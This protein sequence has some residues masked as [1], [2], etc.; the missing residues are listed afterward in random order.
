M[1][2]TL[3]YM[4]DFVMSLF[5]LHYLVLEHSPAILKGW[6]LAFRMPGIGFAEPA[7]ASICE[8]G[9]IQTLC[10]GDRFD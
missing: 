10:Q 9:N 8:G 3:L 2:C 5:L 1:S 4:Y 6:R 7:F